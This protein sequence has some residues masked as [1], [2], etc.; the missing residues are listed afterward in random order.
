MYKEKVHIKTLNLRYFATL[1]FYEVD[2]QVL[3]SSSFPLF[4]FMDL[5]I[6][7]FSYCIVLL[8]V[9]ACRAF[10]IDKSFTAPFS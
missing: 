8:I 6:I 10:L 5:I 9:N 2:N 3:N 4:S 7:F 1:K